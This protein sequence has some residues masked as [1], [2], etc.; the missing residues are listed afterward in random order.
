[1]APQPAVTATGEPTTLADAFRTLASSPEGLTTA[2]AQRHL[3][4]YGRNEPAATAGRSLVVQ[5]V[6]LVANPVFGL[7]FAAVAEIHGR[8]MAVRNAG[9]AVL[10]LS[11]DLD[12]LLKLSD[13]IVVM[14]EGRIVHSCDADNAD[15]H[16][17]GAFMGGHHGAHT[18]AEEAA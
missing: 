13:R 8:I 14:S 11:E 12:E 17:L 4:Q 1:M 5:L 9:G 10:L 7:D 3:A 15:R 18:L 2:E 16:T 6:L